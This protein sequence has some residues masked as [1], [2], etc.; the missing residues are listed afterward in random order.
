[1]RECVFVGSILNRFLKEDKAIVTDIEGTT[2]DIVEGSI[3][4]DG[5]E[6]SL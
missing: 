3:I 2:R 6:L 4:F 5:I 1:M